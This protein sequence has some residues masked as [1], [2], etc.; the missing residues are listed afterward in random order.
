MARDA[1][2]SR[3]RQQ[4]ELLADSALDVDALR[5]EAI[6][7]LRKTIGFELWGC[8]LVDPDTL[9]P[10]RVV[11]SNLPPWGANLPQRWVLDQSVGEIN[12]RVTL[13]RGP[14]H[15]GVLSAATEGDLARCRR[16]RE[17]GQAAGMGDELRAAIVDESGCWGSFELFRAAGDPPFDTGDAE[18]MR[19]A[20]RI[21]ARPLRQGRLGG[22]EEHTVHPD[23]TGV[24]LIGDD[25]RLQGVTPAARAWS[26]LL[27]ARQK[28]ERTPLPLPVYGVVGRL[29]AAEASE[30]PERP[31]RVRVRA[32]D[33]RWALIEAARLD[34]T[35]N[36]IA[37]SIRAASTDEILALACRA[38]GLTARERELVALVL[39]G[40]DTSELA[41]RMFISAYTV[42]D[43]LK[44]VFSKLGVHSRRQLVTGLFG[45]TA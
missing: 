16:W 34:G 40:L 44:S 23:Q 22:T 39:E 10:S 20:G 19:H 4:L 38:Y 36:T 2:R 9:I 3:C 41:T 42:K 14:R 5:L 11:V 7:Q 27:G 24:V 28:P 37:V 43:H 18:L 15:V 12:S 1:A 29:L 35:A 6:D 31:P 33:G 21:L 25:L 26:A 45:Q 30:D 17:M 13:A 8:P 32:S